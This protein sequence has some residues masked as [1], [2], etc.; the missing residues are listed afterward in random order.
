MHQ[1]FIGR[2]HHRLAVLSHRESHR[3]EHDGDVL[4]RKFFLET[5]GVLR[6]RQLLAEI[7]QP[8]TRV[9]ALV[10]Y[11]AQAHVTF[12]EQDARAPV[13]RGYGGCHARGTSS[14]HEHVKSFHRPPP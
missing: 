13:A 7:V 8:E 6:S 12:D 10:E 3:A 11:P 2:K 14:Y 5:V 4:L 9:Y 1:P